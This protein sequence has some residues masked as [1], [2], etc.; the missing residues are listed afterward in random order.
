MRYGNADEWWLITRSGPDVKGTVRHRELAPSRAL[1]RR[2]HTEWKDRPKEEWWPEYVREFQQ[3]F[4]DPAMRASLREIYRRVRAGETIG[5]VC[6][7]PGPVCCHR[8]LIAEFLRQHGLVVEE[9]SAPPRAEKPDRQL[10]FP[11]N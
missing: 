11:L 9:V 3:Q 5:L 8:H 7:C 10:R 1:F 2:R 6:Y 4:S